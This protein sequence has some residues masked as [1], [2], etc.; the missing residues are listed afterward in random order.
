MIPYLSPEQV[1]ERAADLLAQ[2]CIAFWIAEYGHSK[3]Y[4]YLHQTTRMQAMTNAP[5]L[6][7]RSL[8]A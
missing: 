7:Y 5:F 2:H 4:P 3:T 1:S 6:F 8:A